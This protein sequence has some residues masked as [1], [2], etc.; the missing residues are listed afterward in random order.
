LADADAGRFNLRV[1]PEKVA[2]LVR[3]VQRAFA[4]DDSRIVDQQ[5]LKG[6]SSKCSNAPSPPPPPS[7][8]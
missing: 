3:E 8:A 5:Q 6:W 2:P 7:T 4:L 1:S